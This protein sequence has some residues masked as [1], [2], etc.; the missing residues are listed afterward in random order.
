M[1]PFR[2]HFYISNDNFYFMKS[3][4]FFIF[5]IS[6]F[7]FAQNEKTDA[8][9]YVPPNQEAPSKLVLPKHVDK[10]C[11]KWNY[12]LLIRGVFLMNYEFKITDKLTG[13]AGLGLTY[14]D[15]VFEA[16]QL[17][18]YAFRSS[19]ATPPGN[20]VLKPC[21]EAGIR[22]Y[23]GFFNDFNG[24]YLSPAISYRTC[25]FKDPLKSGLNGAF[26]YSYNA[27]YS[28]LDFQLKLGIQYRG[29]W[30]RGILTDIYAG[31]AWRY[32]MV[33]EL[34]EVRNAPLYNASYQ[35]YTSVVNY[36][37]MLLG[38]KTGLPF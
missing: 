6:Q 7:G 33:N 1:S 3:T 26:P 23:P 8:Y 38:F 9:Q 31:L 29:F 36:T 14:R 2:F 37:V 15:P 28:L 13:E 5:F 20:T 21:A 34:V 17:H 10:N 16:F 12:S 19:L 35:K 25:S 27:G 30:R 32:A 11:I 24:V 22:Y 4:A 18:P